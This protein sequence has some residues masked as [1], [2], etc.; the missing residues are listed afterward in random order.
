MGKRVS[1][2]APPQEGSKRRT[3]GG[4]VMEALP[5]GSVVRCVSSGS[6]RSSSLSMMWSL[7]QVRCRLFFLSE[8]EVLDMSVA[9]LVHGPWLE[10][11]VYI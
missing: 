10:L 9:A 5:L 6:P 3:A 7:A 2:G 4:Y 1:G 8:T 11:N